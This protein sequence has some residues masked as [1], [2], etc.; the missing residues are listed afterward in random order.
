M[1]GG[2]G[3]VAVLRLLGTYSLES[4]GTWLA[5]VTLLTPYT[6]APR[7]YEHKTPVCM[8]SI[9]TVHYYYMV[10]CSEGF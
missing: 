2:R 1:I 10:A 5:I 8:A 6:G 9:S 7:L 3:T 4:P